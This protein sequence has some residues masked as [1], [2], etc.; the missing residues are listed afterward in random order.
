MKLHQTVLLNNK[1]GVI[2]FLDFSLEKLRKDIDWTQCFLAWDIKGKYPKILDHTQKGSEA[3]RLYSD[4]NELI[5][6]IILNG[7]LT[8]N[9]VAGIFPANSSG[10][11]YEAV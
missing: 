4:A 1:Q 8:A 3:K 6:E 5:D 11:D 9:G 7:L 2:Y 10:D